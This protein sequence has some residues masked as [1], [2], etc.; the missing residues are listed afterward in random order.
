MIKPQE[1]QIELLESNGE[2]VVFDAVALQESLARAF[3]GAGLRESSYLAE[4]IALAV[5]CAFAHSTRPEPVFSRSEMNSAVVRIL[6]DTGLADVARV[7]R[8]GAPGLLAVSLRTDRPT[9]RGVLD[10]Y[11]AGSS[12]HL[13]RLATKVA[14][15]AAMLG[16]DSASPGLL[17]ELGRYY[18]TEAPVLL[19]EPP[20]A[21]GPVHVVVDQASA[22]S[23]FSAAVRRLFD[24][25][26]LA[27]RC[28]SR[29]FPRI[30]ISCQLRKFAEKEAVTP[31]VTEMLLEPALFALGEQLE[32]CRSEILR[33]YRERSGRPAAELP[34]FITVPDMGEFVALYL[35]ADGHRPGRLARELGQMLCAALKSPV[36][37]FRAVALPPEKA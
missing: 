29:V 32:S 1:Y 25:G 26:I 12:G 17:L 28:D 8:Q 10:K 2:R 19:P 15:A 9:I 37:K 21:A 30:A 14:D 33:L 34:L 3:R 35:G 6:E 18:E 36:E 4:D 22:Y 31:P 23:A 16:I 13:E 27:F 7:Y 11:L 20:P 5:E 24:D